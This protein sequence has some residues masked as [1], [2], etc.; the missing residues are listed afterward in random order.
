VSLSA[1]RRAW[2]SPAQL[3]IDDAMRCAPRRAPDAGDPEILS[4]K[5]PLELE[6]AA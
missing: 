6:P 5:L 4:W 2:I 1:E 3:D